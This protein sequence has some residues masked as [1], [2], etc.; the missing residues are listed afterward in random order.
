MIIEI[1]NVELY[2]NNKCILN[3]IYLK[4]ETGKVSS[5]LG[6]NGSGKS[7]LMDIIFGVLTPKYKL[8]RFNGKPILEPIYKTKLISYLPQFNFTPNGM[9]LKIAFKLFNVDWS[10]FISTF[11]TFTTYENINFNKLSGGERRVVEI[12]LIL[13]K[14]AKVILL[15]E[16]FTG[17]S[18]IYIQQIQQL[19]ANE[20]QHK[21]ILLTDHRYKEVLEISDTIY[22]LKNG[23][24]TII[25][26]IKKLEDYNYV[27][28]GRLD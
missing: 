19:I 5:I 16:P 17:V 13:K 4:A 1:D 18:P 6:R 8:I 24:T 9:K 3:G 7:C 26:S 2:F 22:L 21:A 11:D 12:Y 20:K 14:Q 27:S 15:D 28:I 25:N 10:T 23:C